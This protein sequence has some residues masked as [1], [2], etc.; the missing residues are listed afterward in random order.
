VTLDGIQIKNGVADF[1][2]GLSGSG[3]QLTLSRNVVSGNQATASGGGIYLA[4]N[5][6]LDLSASQVISNTAGDTGGG[7]TLTGSGASSTLTRSWI[8]GNTAASGGGGIALS[9]GTVK[10]ETIMLVD[11]TVT[12][13]AAPGAGLSASD[14]A[15]MLLASTIAHNTGGTG[16]GLGLSGTA[17]LTATNVL[18]AGQETG[19]ALVSPSSA[20][21]DG[22]LWGSGAT[23]ANGNNTAGTGSVVIQHA[24]TGDPAFVGLDP[25]NLRTYFH[26]GQ[27][28]PAYDH[29]VPAAYSSDIDNQA[30][31]GSAADLG[32]DEYV[33]GHG[34]TF[35][36]DTEP[37]GDIEVGTVDG[38]P[39]N[40]HGAFF[41]T[42]SQ[43][44]ANDTAAHMFFTDL[45]T[46]DRL[47]NYTFLANIDADS[48]AEN[49]LG[50]YHISRSTYAY[51]A[52]AQTGGF[53]K[54]E[55]ALY[56]ITV[57]DS[58][59]TI[60]LYSRGNGYGQAYFD[61][62]AQYTEGT[63]IAF[64][65]GSAW[66]NYAEAPDLSAQRALDDST[67]RAGILTTC[68]RELN[69]RSRYWLDMN[70]GSDMGGL[71]YYF[72]TISQANRF[73][74]LG[75]CF[76]DEFRVKFMAADTLELQEFRLRPAIYSESLLR[77]I[78]LPLAVR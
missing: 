58:P 73:P 8:F 28:S 54:V 74:T 13:P 55:A 51:I 67:G 31:H 39:E 35:H 77:S 24:V 63:T 45:A 68:S 9:G 50:A 61:I 46:Q 19:I 38:S 22:V 14:S 47:K 65:G 34:V 18:I 36:V 4:G 6:S 25:A 12:A 27:T 11:N 21:V 52:P 76:P 15:L 42:G 71:T 57:T 75:A 37:G 29:A 62:Y 30:I 78:Y 17:V 3:V 23:W 7:I 26:I 70:G 56:R 44:V 16:A 10:L 64:R 1:G 60:L 5:S 33:T 66:F 40:T 59:E 43:W 72:H 48:P 2:A 49:D 53:Y 69:D 32:A 20:A 41:W